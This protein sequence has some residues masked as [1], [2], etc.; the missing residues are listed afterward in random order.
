[1][2]NYGFGSLT[3]TMRNNKKYWTGR[4]YVGE[5]LEGNQIRKSFSGYNKSKV[6][7]KMK[8]A[9]VSTNISGIYN[10]G[11]ETLGQFLSNWLFNIKI[12]EV[13]STT[14]NRYDQLLRLHILNYPFSKVKIKDITILNLQIFIN[15]ISENTN[16]MNITRDV[17]SLIKMCLTYSITLGMLDNNPAEYIKIPKIEKPVS[18]NK[19]RIFSQEEQDKVIV[20]LDFENVVD[21]MIFLDF[22]TGLRRNEIRALQ[23]GAFKDGFLEINKQLGRE[24]TFENNKSK[25]NSNKLRSLKTESS[26]RS[27]PLPLVAINLLNKIKVESAKKYFRLGL[28]FNDDSFIFTD[29]LCKPIEEKRA[30]RRLKSICKKLEI[31][32][33]TQ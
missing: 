7:E 16:S 5:D 9:Q 4:V 2:A 15:K 21:Q 29:D 30:N 32:P 10:S 8:K 6:I 12:K 28:K 25:V 18:S 22:F 11:N 24:Y 17:L 13:K 26:L 27:L 3:Y 23:W 33:L 20:Y 14:L 31:D 19:Y 1:M